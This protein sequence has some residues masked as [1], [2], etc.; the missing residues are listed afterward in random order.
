MKSPPTKGRK[1]VRNRVPAVSSMK[2]IRRGSDLSTYFLLKEV[3][4]YNDA[5]GHGVVHA[6]NDQPDAWQDEYA[7]QQLVPKEL[8]P[9][10]DWLHDAGK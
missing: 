8:P 5:D 3:K 7:Q 10:D 2:V 9:N 4:P 1:G 6:V